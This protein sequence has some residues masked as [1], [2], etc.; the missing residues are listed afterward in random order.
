M[1]GAGHLVLL[2]NSRAAVYHGLAVVA[3]EAF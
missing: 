2:H 3:R 1:H